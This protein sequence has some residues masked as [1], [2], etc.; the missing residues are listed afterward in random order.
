MQVV[1]LAG[2]FGTRMSEY[3]N[4]VPKP[5]VEICGKPI[6]VRIMEHYADY[7]INDFILALGYKSNYVKEYF[8]NLQ[9]NLSNL[10]I[11]FGSGERVQLNKPSID[12]RIHLVDT[13]FDTMTGGRLSR[14]RTFIDGDNFMLTY[15]DG[16]SD[17]NIR[18]LID[19]HLRHGRIATVTAVRPSAR[20]GELSIDGNSHVNKFREKPQTE[21]GWVN[22]GF[23]VFRREVFEY[24]EG[25]ACVLEQK[26]LQ[27][28]ARDG[29][30]MAFQHTGFWQCMDTKRDKDYLETVFEGK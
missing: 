8:S 29:Q 13:G 28:I 16:V 11:D 3:T 1:I 27:N 24:L 12:W 30:L 17:V 19:F 10:Y 2:G 21:Q 23:M 5:M 22:G 25:D 6:L 18:A 26:P 9:T 7:G 14:L 15:G 20:F 4:S